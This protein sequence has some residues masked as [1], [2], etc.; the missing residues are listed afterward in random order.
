MSGYVARLL[1]I[2]RGAYVRLRCGCGAAAQVLGRRDQDAGG[3][4]STSPHEIL[5][6]ARRSIFLPKMRAIQIAKKV[7]PFWSN[8]SCR[9]GEVR[10]K[11]Q[12]CGVCHSDTVA[13]VAIGDPPAVIHLVGIPAPGLAPDAAVFQNNMM[14]TYNVLATKLKL[15]P[16]R[17]ATGVRPQDGDLP[18]V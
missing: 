1:G 7:A 11:V 2:P 4:C 14:T 8:G 3:P 18:V 5:T 16:R 13:K 9:R 10:V 12:A 17:G 6:I 15:V